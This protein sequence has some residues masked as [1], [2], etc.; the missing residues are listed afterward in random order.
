M[1]SACA[2]GAGDVG[3]MRGLRLVLTA[4]TPGAPWTEAA[5]AVFERAW[6]DELSAPPSRTVTNP[7]SA[8]QEWAQGQGHPLPEYVVIGRSGPDHAPEYEVEVRIAQN[9][10]AAASGPPPGPGGWARTPL[11]LDLAGGVPLDLNLSARTLVF[12]SP[13]LDEMPSEI[14]RLSAHFRPVLPDRD[15]IRKV[16]KFRSFSEA[17]GFMTRCALAAEKANHHPE[18]T[19]RFNIVDVTLITH[20]CAG[21]SMLDITLARQMDRLSGTAEVVK[22]H[23]EPISCLCETRARQA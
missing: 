4:G 9:G 20:D 17:W 18:W 10:T 2:P 16:W 22:N 3:Q 5:K 6:S 23:A 13:R 7:K 8:L 11:Q 15:A 1:L 14:L 12:L 19:N 21:L